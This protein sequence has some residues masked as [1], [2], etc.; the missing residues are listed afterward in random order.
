MVIK[1]SSDLE[2]AL[3]E[4][5]LREGMAPDVLATS[6]LRER[7]L[8]PRGSSVAPDH[9]E[10]LVRGLASDCGVSLPHAALS[11]EGLYE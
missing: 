1:I 4:S 10:Q 3:N 2:A 11:S 9:R 6:V 7:F 8:T 5:A